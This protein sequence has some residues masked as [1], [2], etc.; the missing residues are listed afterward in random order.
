M[1]RRQFLRL[2]SSSL[3]LIGLPRAAAQTPYRQVKSRMTEHFIRPQ[4]CVPVAGKFPHIQLWNPR[5][6]GMLVSVNGIEVTRNGDF[7]WGRHTGP[8]LGQPES[9]PD[10]YGM[11]S[12][13]TFGED[14]GLNVDPTSPA[15]YS[16]ARV[17]HIAGTWPRGDNPQAPLQFN[18]LYRIDAIGPYTGVRSPF[19]PTIL[20]PNDG[21]I[22]RGSV[23][24]A[25]L[26][27]SFAWAE[28][29]YVPPPP[30]PPVSP[31][32]FDMPGAY[33]LTVPQY[34]T[35]LRIE[36][37][38]PTGGS[39]G[40]GGGNDGGAASGPTTIVALGL[41]ANPG[42]PGTMLAGG[43]G[44]TASGGDTNQTGENGETPGSGYSGKGGNSG[45][46]NPALGG[47][48]RTTAGVG[49]SGSGPGA[50]PGGGYSGVGQGAG[51][52]GGGGRAVKTYT[53]QQLAPGTLITLVI[54]SGGFKGIGQYPGVEGANGSIV[55]T[56]D[57]A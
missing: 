41:L 23:L 11:L 30:P 13:A 56:W 28:S 36:V 25:A 16:K 50:G 52:A 57:P 26:T 55:L 12:G 3:M 14:R 18:Q 6:S 31:M 35:E 39:G 20:R 46:P 37:T 48:R 27:G 1:Q 5:D 34:T 9:Y 32:T 29:G 8:A 4:V 54:P 49:L 53:P 43:P 15:A 19:L 45:G 38:G 22:V 21:L 51:G 47:A 10:L 33:Q 2:G 7:S 42:G 44:G 24:G 40:D 17:R